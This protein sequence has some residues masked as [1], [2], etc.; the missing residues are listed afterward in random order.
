LDNAIDADRFSPIKH[1]ANTSAPGATLG[2]NIEVAVGIHSGNG[3]RQRIWRQ[4]D[5]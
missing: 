4:L 3:E 1:S 5:F 2:K